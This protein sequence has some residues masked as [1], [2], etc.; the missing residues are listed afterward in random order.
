MSGF[1]EEAAMLLHVAEKA[2][3]FSNLR[4][5]HD[6]AI[7]RLQEIQS[8]TS[9]PKPIVESIPAE[10]FQEKIEDNNEG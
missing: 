5:L 9:E 4:P 10:T 7:K 6:A 8:A 2:L 1:F 3:Q